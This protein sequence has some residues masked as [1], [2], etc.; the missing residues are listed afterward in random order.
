MAHGGR[1]F[2]GCGQRG[3]VQVTQVRYSRARGLPES[4]P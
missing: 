1:S 3:R 4:L 2:G